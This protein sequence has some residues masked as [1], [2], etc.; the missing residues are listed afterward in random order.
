MLEFE[1]CICSIFDETV[2]EDIYLFFKQKR[3]TKVETVWE[4]G[5]GP[6]VDWLWDIVYGVVVVGT[7]MLE[8]WVAAFMDAAKGV[9]DVPAALAGAS[10]IIVERLSEDAGLRQRVR[11]AVFERGHVRTRKGEKAKTPSRF[12]NYFSYQEPVRALLTPESSHRYLAMRCGW[13]EEELVLSM[14]GLFVEDGVTDLLV[15]ELLVLF[16]MV[17][18]LLVV[19]GFVGVVL[20]KCVVWLVLCV[21]VVLLIE[22]EVHKVLREIVDVVVVGVFVENVCKLLLFVLVGFKF[23]LGVDLGFCIGCK[24]VVVDV[25][26]W[27]IGFGFMYLEMLVGKVV[28]VFILVDLV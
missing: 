15:E 11:S 5:L 27:Y 18:C 17:V 24:L 25:F 7:E 8:T 3:K 28:V 19:V 16:E 14:G 20:L 13:M 1:V 4:A 6:L 2:L 21:Y 23:V 26:G 9:V 22:T 12:D 10:D